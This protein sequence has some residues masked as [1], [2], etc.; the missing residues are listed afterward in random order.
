[1]RSPLAR[2]YYRFQNRRAVHLQIVIVVKLENLKRLH[3][4][5]TSFVS[6]T[7]SYGSVKQALRFKCNYRI[8]RQF[9]KYDKTYECVLLYCFARKGQS[10][11]HKI[12]RNYQQR[13]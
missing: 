5:V 2:Q 6:S 1:M 10:S 4:F 12:Q 11:A 7:I 3:S 9:N 8:G 13:C